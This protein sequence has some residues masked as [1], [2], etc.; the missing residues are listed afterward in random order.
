VCSS[1]LSLTTALVHNTVTV[2]NLDQFAR[3]GRFLYLDWFNAYRSGSVETDP[4]ILQRMRGW[5]RGYSKQ[6]IR[7]ERTVTAYSDGHWQIRDDLLPFRKHWGKKLHTF[8]LRWLLPDW[9]WRVESSQPGLMLRLISPYGPVDLHLDVTGGET[10]S[11]D[12][13]RAGEGVFMSGPGDR[14]PPMEA[15][16]CGWVS[17]TYGVK[18]PALSLSVETKSVYDV[19]FASEFI[20]PK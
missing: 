1:D 20:F 12:L 18:V 15:T 5:H 17:P 8:C 10:A 11:V 2:N 19:K 16:I 13:V 14:T 4:A 9:E 6:G 3:A 7:H